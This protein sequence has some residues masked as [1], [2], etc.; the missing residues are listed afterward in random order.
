M[1]D[2]LVVRCPACGDARPGEGGQCRACGQHLPQGMVAAAAPPPARS[3]ERR[4]V[5]ILFSDLS[6]FTALSER[7]DPEEL[8]GFMSRLFA[9][10][11][12]VVA[13][14]DG[15]L[16]KTIG[17]EVMILFGAPR[18]H[19]DDPV[20]AIRAAR[21]IHAVAEELGKSLLPAGSPL[22]T[23]HS[24]INT[25]LVVTGGGDARFPGVEVSGFTIALASRLTG[26]AGPG[27]IVVG[28]ETYK[29]ARG[30]F[31][32]ELL[33]EV[34]LKGIV[35]TIACHRVIGPLVAPRKVHGVFGR[36]APLVGRDRQIALLRESA[37][38]C[39]GGRRGL[40]TICGEAGTGKSRL[41]E[42]LRESLEGAQLRWIEGFAHAYSQNIPYAPIIDLAN[43]IWHIDEH[44]HPDA[45][46]RKISAGLHAAGLDDRAETDF[47]GL[48]ALPDARAFVSPELW[49]LNLHRALTGLFES[50]TAQAPTVV[51]FEDLH[52]ADPSTLDFIRAYLASPRP[53]ALLILS[54]RPEFV[55]RTAQLLAE[56]DGSRVEIVLE[57]LSADESQ[58]ML[59]GLLGGR[60]VPGEL[61]LFLRERVAGNPFFLEEIATSLIEEGDLFREGDDWRVR[62][63]LGA[64]E[65]P[66]TV[67]SVI[68]TRL[69]RLD[70]GAKTALQEASVIGKIFSLQILEQV[71]ETGI[72]LTRHLRQL[73]E[74]SLVHLLPGRQTQEYQF[75]HA[76][77]QEVAYNS[78]LRA[79]RQAIHERIARAVERTAGDRCAEFYETLA[80]HYRRGNSFDKATE[81]LVL[82]GEKSLRRY[83][84]EEANSSFGKAF[85]LLVGLASRSAAQDRFLVA[86]IAKWTEV[87]YYRADFRGLLRLLESY[88]GLAESLGD[89]ALLATYLKWLG[90]ALWGREEYRLAYRCL[91]RAAHLGREVGDDH[92]VRH[93]WAWLIWTCAE[94]GFLDKALEFGRRVSAADPALEADHELFFIATS[95]I[96]LTHVYRGER[97]KSREAAAALLR[98][99]ERHANFRSA[100]EGHHIM[101]WSNFA[102]GDYAGAGAAFKAAIGVAAYPYYS[103]IPRVGLAYSLLSSGRYREAEETLREVTSFSEA[104]GVEMLGRP[105]R[106]LHGLVTLALGRMSEGMTTIERMRREWEKRSR[107]Y[108]LCALEFSLGRFYVEIARRTTP[109]RLSVV[110][111]NML[112]LARHAPWARGRAEA[113]FGRCITLA[114]QIGARGLAAQALYQF[115]LLD[116]DRG[117]REE[118]RRRLARAVEIF[119]DCGAEVHLAQARDTLAALS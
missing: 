70:P 64:A 84:L 48:Y 51:C 32:F 106:A 10:A 18:S 22:L 33:P 23:M 44:D 53:A 108:A 8:N 49:K 76:L 104:R 50:L 28:P 78:L 109:L 20:R 67:F 116:R 3:A 57:P 111:R 46:Q 82:S 61:S 30:S 13:R 39:A 99:G 66:S 19:E 112:F 100:V 91:V 24:G 73:E 63:S 47:G 88:R 12:Q 6:G 86:L 43:R 14:Y 4:H 35:E 2:Q 93:S 105:C 92:I 97:E 80:H 72:D 81:Y 113:H 42:E 85:D 102:A 41:I 65:L 83:A 58:E 34:P 101:G 56:V 25:G 90:F 114:E 60:T 52:W 71:S 37:Q 115:A 117:G 26:V 95:G 103:M 96:G 94:W 7:L 16:A 45:V 5:T 29:Q 1:A 9:M 40:V 21:E 15:L 118:A 77:T 55:P 110:F 27:Q 119:A 79:Q 59:G 36:R 31:E 69:D 89:K 17:D 62:A 74:H 54:F 107:R 11:A 75:R 68:S 87:Y 38:S 98:H